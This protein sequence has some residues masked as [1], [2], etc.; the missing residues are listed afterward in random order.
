ME[1]DEIDSRIRDLK[2]ELR[3]LYKRREEL[4][5][6]YFRHPDALADLSI[7]PARCLVDLFGPNPMWSADDWK[8]AVRHC[9]LA[10]LVLSDNIGKRS[11]WELEYWADAN[12]S[13]RQLNDL[14]KEKRHATMNRS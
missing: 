10:R 8:N 7:R 13:R 14:M 5:P 2:A 6:D 11:I 9:D 4:Q 1:M 12:W 3:S